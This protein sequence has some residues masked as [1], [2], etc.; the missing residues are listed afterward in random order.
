MPISKFDPGAQR[1]EGVAFEMAHVALQLG[2]QAIHFVMAITS[3]DGIILHT[4]LI[5]W[6]W[7][8]AYAVELNSDAQDQLV[9]R[10]RR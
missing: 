4:G 2:N 10:C 7:A 9:C 8:T 1:V 6:P 5:A 3:A